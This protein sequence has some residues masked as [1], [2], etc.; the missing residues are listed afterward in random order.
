MPVIQ[1]ASTARN[2]GPTMT[3]P[4]EANSIPVADVGEDVG[5]ASISVS[6]PRVNQGSGSTACKLREIPD[7]PEL[8][9]PLRTVT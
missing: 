4:S 9:P 8:E 1:A 7:L 5:I 6:T 3:S 2:S